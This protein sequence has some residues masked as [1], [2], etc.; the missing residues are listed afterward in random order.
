MTGGPGEDHFVFGT[1]SGQDTVL[2]FEDGT[3]L[4]QLTGGLTFS[5][6]TVTTV[7]SGQRIALAS[8]PSVHITLEGLNPGDI[9]A[10]DFT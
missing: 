10:D 4:I 3:D 2:D 5:D 1:Q 7:A 8:D 9:T 6:L